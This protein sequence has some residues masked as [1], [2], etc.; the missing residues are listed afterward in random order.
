MHHAV[1]TSAKLTIINQCNYTVW[2]A[3]FPTDATSESPTGFIL[4]PGENSIITTSDGWTGRV[5]GRTLCTI[6][7]TGK[8]SCVTGDCGSGKIACD[9][10]GSPPLTL[11]EFTL[12]GPNNQDFYDVS[13][14]DGYNVPMNIVP[15]DSS[16][17]C[18][19]TGCPT[20][21]N[22]V[23]PTEL[24]LMKN[25]KFVACHSPCA[26]GNHSTSGKCEPSSYSKIFKKACPEAYT[27]PED[28]TST[29]T[30]S[31]TDYQVVICPKNNTRL[32]NIVKFSSKVANN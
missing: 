8:F 25:G 29:F 7:S 13:L 15:L 2:P 1:V 27:Y 22:A 24:K 18:N 21:L 5:W 23:C 20:D 14:V 3:S 11:A 4:K 19:S 17:M 16:G 12:N 26:V 6:D 10:K 30:C 31:A 9:T 28:S 32:D